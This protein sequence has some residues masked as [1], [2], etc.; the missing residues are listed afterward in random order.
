MADRSQK[1]SLPG[2]VRDGRVVL[3]G[4]ALPDGTRVAVRVLE[5]DEDAEAFD[6]TPDEKAE[7]LASIAEAD[8]GDGMDA[9]DHLKSLRDGAGQSP[10]D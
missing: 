7:L 9:Y 6:V 3:T 5:P 2:I 4:Q 8:R 10:S 1:S